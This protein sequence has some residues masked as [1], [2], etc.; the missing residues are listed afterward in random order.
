ME[1]INIF[2]GQNNSGK[3]NVIRY[4]S[5]Y[6]IP[7]LSGKAPESLATDLPRNG[8]TTPSCTWMLFPIHEMYIEKALPQDKKP[9][10]DRFVTLMQM[11]STT[12]NDG[13]MIWLPVEAKGSRIHKNADVLN[14]IIGK[15]TRDKEHTLLNFWQHL[16]NGSG[17]NVHD[18]LTDILQ[19]FISPFFYSVDVKIVQALRRIDTRLEEFRPEFGASA[20][21]DK[22]IDAL[23]ALASPPW[24]RQEDRKR[25]AAIEHF[26]NSVL[27][28]SDV[29]VE[30]P[31]DKS[32]IN[33]NMD[34]RVLPVEALGT[35]LHQ[36]ILMAANVI[37][38][39]NSVVCIEEPE[40][41]LHPE[42]QRQFMRFLES[43]GTNQYFI[44]THSAHVMD[45]TDAAVFS[46]ELKEGSTYF[47]RAI[48]RQSRRSICD[49]LGYRPSDLLQ[50]NCVMWVEGPSDRLYLNRWIN[51]KDSSLVEGIHYSIM[52]YG[53][54]LLSHLKVED[55]EID[56][57]IHL[58]P[59]NRFP[60][61]LIDSDK[62]SSHARM[63][64]TK[65]R[66]V[67]EFESMSA[68]CWVTK[69]KEIENYLS[70][71]TRNVASKMVHANAREAAYRGNE[72]CNGLAY[73]TISGN[74]IENVDKIKFA[75]AALTLE[76]DWKRLDLDHQVSQL[77]S[78]IKRANRI[79]HE[80]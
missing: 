37:A 17:G 79:I 40:L 12:I 45:A 43:E 77:V 29:K 80:Q 15:H 4:V 53:G 10:A 26:V 19:V 9:L 58:L 27:S 8:Y 28:R 73:K 64:D 51:E 2:I 56:E 78:Y 62:R 21:N 71:E 20:G 54:R 16:R 59:I 47:R 1:K 31:H 30:I 18:W 7:A 68:F 3:S 61:M 13:R 74:V 50:S 60:C 55:S 25:F 49:D 5:R 44:T 57:F 38:V 42:L 35:G 11:L 46:V 75:K 6:I 66:I 22:I 48:G 24:D 67:R 63:N 34:G 36:I 32:T 52:F 72:Y 69:G 23:A 14:A 65:K 33:I 39:T 41:H 76:T 70:D